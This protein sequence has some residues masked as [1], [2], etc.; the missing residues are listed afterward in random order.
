VLQ[1]EEEEA[2][3][4]IGRTLTFYLEWVGLGYASPIQ[5]K[6]LW[7]GTVRDLNFQRWSEVLFT[8]TPFFWLSR[9]FSPTGNLF[10][11]LQ[12]EPM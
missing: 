11:A 2:R 3:S 9:P 1:Q 7:V 12:E 4:S 10:G 8:K 5:S 6:V